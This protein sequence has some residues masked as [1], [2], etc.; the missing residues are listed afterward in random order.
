MKRLKILLAVAV[1]TLIGVFSQVAVT[2]AA[3]NFEVEAQAASGAIFMGGTFHCSGTVIGNSTTDALFLTARHCIVD[4]STN[5]INKDLWVTFAPN[6]AG[7]FYKAA[8]VLI[9][10][11][12]DLA[13]LV[14]ENGQDLPAVDITTEEAVENGDPIFNVSYPLDSGKITFH[15]EFIAPVFAHFPESLLKGYPQWKHT[16]PINM[17]IAHGSSG[18][19]VFDKKSQSLIGVVVGTASEGTLNIAEPESLVVYLLN[20]SKENSP[21]AWTKAYPPREA[22]QEWWFGQ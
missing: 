15:G 1:L 18:S 22:S 11:T 13:V 20:H 10:Q 8:P 6:E 3:P 14:L 12:E 21:E 16:M 19:G 5:N 17:T 4:E 7:P 9:S 2:S